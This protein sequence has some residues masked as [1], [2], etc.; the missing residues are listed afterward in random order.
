MFGDGVNAVVGS[1]LRGSGR[2]SLGAFLNLCSCESL[3]AAADAAACASTHAAAPDWLCSAL[4]CLCAD[5]R[6]CPRCI[7]H[8][9]PADWGLGLPSSYLLA[10]RFGLGMR[11]LWAGLVI[12][13][14]VQGVVMLLVLARSQ[15]EREATAAAERVHGGGAGDELSVEDSATKLSPASASGK[16]GGRSDSGGRSRDGGGGGRGRGWRDAADLEDQ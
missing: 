8:C 2:Q 11:G 5:R 12:C 9:P 14:S 6:P 1:I 7:P 4:L 10:I 16:L 13:T 3:P 15:W